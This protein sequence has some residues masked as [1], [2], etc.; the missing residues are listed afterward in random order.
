MTETK[1][2]VRFA[3]EAEAIKDER[4][5]A[6]GAYK[7][8]VLAAYD[9]PLFLQAIRE[10]EEFW[11][12]PG[13][14]I[15]ADQRNRLG[16]FRFPLSGGG[17]KDIVVKEY[18]SRGVNMLKS[19]F[20]PSK[21]ARAWRG[22]LALSQRGL[23]TARPVAYFERRRAGF[24]ERSFFLSERVE[25][26][27]EIRGLF[28]RPPASDLDPLLSAL[29]GHL[30]LCHERGI[31]HRDL[32][33]GNVL[34]KRD[35]TGN[36]TFY[37]LDTNRIRVRKKIGVSNRVKNLIRLGIPPSLQKPFLKKYFGERSLRMTSWVWYKMN[38]A[39]YSG[40]VNLKKKLRL[41]RLAR[42]LGV[43]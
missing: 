26:A 5:L 7:G 1:M 33:D 16:V 39:V 14:E 6:F 40:Y 34:V 24:V 23:G 28:R 29:A 31:F 8:M 32:S 20:L 21:A 38:K 13:V 3:R 4:P 43:Q 27:E 2:N 17:T 9:D 42:K 12:Q 15:L 18:S 41:R 22:A 30:S 11:R 37:L 19:L 35:E 25:G 10:P 36:F